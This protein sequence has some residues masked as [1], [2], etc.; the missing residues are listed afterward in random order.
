MTQL[1]LAQLAARESEPTK[2]PCSKLKPKVSIL[3]LKISEGEVCCC[4]IGGPTPR[5]KTTADELTSRSQSARV[6]VSLIPGCTGREKAALDSNWQPVSSQWGEALLPPIVCD[7]GGIT[8][9]SE[10]ER[11]ARVDRRGSGEGVAV[12]GR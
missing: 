4:L 10:S 8:D 7:A 6:Q 2:K 9:A 1:C 11:A 5:D 12:S 3:T